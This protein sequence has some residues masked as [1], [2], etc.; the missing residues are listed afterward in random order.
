MSVEE[1][2]RGL[3]EEWR[4]RDGD[5]RRGNGLSVRGGGGVIRVGSE[6]CR[7][8]ERGFKVVR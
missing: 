2:S 6:R 7:G 3:G 4:E 8:E 1:V 5:G